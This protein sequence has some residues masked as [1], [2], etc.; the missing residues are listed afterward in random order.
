MYDYSQ[1]HDHSN[2]LFSF[3]NSLN[4]V[5]YD[6]ALQEEHILNTLF[7]VENADSNVDGSTMTVSLSHQK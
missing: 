5:S 4:N 2:G 3:D 1:Q 6:R 7:S